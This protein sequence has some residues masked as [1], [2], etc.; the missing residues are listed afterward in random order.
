MTESRTALITGAT[1]GLGRALAERFDEE[2]WNLIMNGQRPGDPPVPIRN[3]HSYIRGDL[4]MR[5]TMDDLHQ[6]AKRR[7]LDILINCAG[8]RFEKT[9][10]MEAPYEVDEELAL[11]LEVPILLTRRMW[12]I[13]KR[14][15]SGTIVNIGSTAADTPGK[16][17]AV[18]AASKGGLRSF[19]QAIQ[20]D[21]TAI[22]VRALYVAPGAMS[23]EMTMGRDDRGKL[24]DPRHVAQ[25]IFTL[26]HQPSSLRVT[27]VTMQRMA[28]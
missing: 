12:P 21:A 10:C 23:T 28:Y 14:Q 6:A 18:Y 16:D 2:G 17:E 19:T 4:R 15:R 3:G 5:E 20:R 22:N 24:M 26:C 25:T 13:F 1:S 8:V 27:D 9:L 7:G 11:N